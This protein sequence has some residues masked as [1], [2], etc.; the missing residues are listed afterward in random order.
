MK[1]KKAN[2]NRIASIRLAKSISENNE[3]LDGNEVIENLSSYPKDIFFKQQQKN[4][5]NLKTQFF[6]IDNSFFNQETKNRKKI[7]LTQSK[8]IRVYLNYFENSLL[9]WKHFL[10]F[11][12]IQLTEDPN[13]R[14][15]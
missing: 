2:F 5:N 3:N 11:C 6:K 14:N 13:I 7:K 8:A 9:S 10:T 1:K 12:I 4:M 15:I